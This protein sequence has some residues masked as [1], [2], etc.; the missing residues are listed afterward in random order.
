MVANIHITKNLHKY[1]HLPP[2]L[3]RT[4]EAE[5]AAIL[6]RFQTLCDTKCEITANVRMSKTNCYLDWNS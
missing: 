5:M 2:L 4:M 6:K 3:P 1:N